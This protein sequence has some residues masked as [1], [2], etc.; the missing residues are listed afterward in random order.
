MSGDDTFLFFVASA[1]GLD[2]FL[3]CGQKI[4]DRK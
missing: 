1:S 4:V 3:D 2:F